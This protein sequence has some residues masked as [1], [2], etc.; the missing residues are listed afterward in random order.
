MLFFS[1]DLPNYY[2]AITWFKGKNSIFSVTKEAS[3]R[4]IYIRD[5][6]T[7]KTV[8][9][10]SRITGFLGFDAVQ[11]KNG[12]VKIYVD[13]GLWP[14]IKNSDAETFLKENPDISKS[15]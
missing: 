11:D 15:I 14:S 10:A 1:S 8:E 6:N 3:D 7:G 13:G 2:W 4:K 9:V 12:L 5:L